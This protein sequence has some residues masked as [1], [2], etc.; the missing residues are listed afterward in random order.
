MSPPAVEATC[1]AIA[2]E[3]EKLTRKN[4]PP[5][6]LV[7]PHIRAGLKQLT[8][9]QMPRLIVLSYNEVTRDTV[10]ESIGMV[11]DGK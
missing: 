6:I 7:S 9:S 1:R 2:K 4:K 5:V 11:V 8:S 3:T 10:I